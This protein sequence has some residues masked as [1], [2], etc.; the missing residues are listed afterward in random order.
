MPINIM[1]MEK[2]YFDRILI[3][4]NSGSGKSWLATQL[5]KILSIQI[6]HFDKHFWEP[7]GFNKKRDRQVVYQEIITLAQEE[8]WIMKGFFTSSCY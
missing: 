2:N 1:L 6:V 8:N 4:G 7:G 5:S 3:I